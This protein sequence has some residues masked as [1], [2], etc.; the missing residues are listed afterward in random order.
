[1]A[2]V[3]VPCSVG[4]PP[5]PFL[6]KAG[7]QAP[8]LRYDQRCEISAASLEGPV[9]QPVSLDGPHR[10]GRRGAGTRV[11]VNRLGKALPA[12]PLAGSEKSGVAAGRHAAGSGQ[13]GRLGDAGPG[14]GRRG[15]ARAGTGHSF[16]QVR[17]ARFA[18]DVQ[19]PGQADP[20]PA[21]HPLAARAAHRDAAQVRAVRG[22]ARRGDC[23][24]DV[25]G[26]VGLLAAGREPG[27][28]GERGRGGHRHAERVRGP[29]GGL[30]RSG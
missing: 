11:P 6:Q 14:P 3:C 22:R 19:A 25:H 10:H 15:E 1:L 5:P 23:G 13:R 9:V 8:T 18:L 12:S 30:H 16:A 24:R 27:R 28:V 4:P 17:G 29:G 2:S 7:K 26:G 21:P 20:V